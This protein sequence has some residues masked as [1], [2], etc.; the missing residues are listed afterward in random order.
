MAYSESQPTVTLIAETTFGTTDLY[1]FVSIST[2]NARVS[3]STSIHPAHVIGTLLSETYTTSTGANESVT[4]GLLRGVGK[5]RMAVSTLD[6]GA[7]IAAS[8]SGFGVAPTTLLA[9]LGYIV[10]G[11][12]TSVGRINSVL[13][14]QN[15]GST[16]L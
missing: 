5:V 13:F 10:E 15:A 8:S 3:I 4:I 12:S 14:V 11:A 2:A 1:K 9:A 6:A 7:L 16:T